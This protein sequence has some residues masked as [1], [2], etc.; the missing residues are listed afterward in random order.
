LHYLK[1][2]SNSRWGSLNTL[3]NQYPGNSLHMAIAAEFAL[4]QKDYIRAAQL[5]VNLSDSMFHDAINQYF[6]APDTVPEDQLKATRYQRQNGHFQHVFRPEFDCPDP[7]AEGLF[8]YVDRQQNVIAIEMTYAAKSRWLDLLRQVNPELTEHMDYF[9]QQLGH[10]AHRVTSSS[11]RTRG[12]NPDLTDLKSIRNTI[13]H[14]W[15]NQHQCQRIWHS[16]VAVELWTQEHSLFTNELCHILAG[17]DGQPGNAQ[18]Y[19]GLAE[20][21]LAVLTQEILDD[22]QN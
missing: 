10:R 22:P 3:I 14:Q 1:W 11:R 13:T 19:D 16:F 8:R 9:T 5:T 18:P 2:Q 4:K 17:L 21:A 15:L 6:L 12:R 7:V 20:Q